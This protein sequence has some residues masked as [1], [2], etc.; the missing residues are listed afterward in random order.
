MMMHALNNDASRKKADYRKNL[1]LKLFRECIDMQRE[2]D[3]PADLSTWSIS[4]L[5]EQFLDNEDSPLQ[6]VT[7][8]LA[9]S[10]PLLSGL[11]HP[12]IRLMT[13]G[14]GRISAIKA[15]VDV[16]S[17]IPGVRSTKS[18]TKYHFS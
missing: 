8:M 16:M 14:N 5:V 17:E 1:L 9:Q 11:Q 15:A 12:T 3:N 13:E 18:Q 4:N 7:P 10:L 6:S 2:L